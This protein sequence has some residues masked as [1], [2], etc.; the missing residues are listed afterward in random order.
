[1]SKSLI[2]API[3]GFPEFLPGEQIEFDKMLNVVRRHYQ[4]AGFT[5]IETPSIERMETLRAAKA[6]DEVKGQMYRVA[7]NLDESMTDYGLHFDLTVPFARYVAQHRTATG[8]NNQP[9]MP[10]P[11]RRSQIQKVW[12]G[13]KTQGGRYREFYQCDIDAIGDGELSHLVDAEIPYVMYGIFK[14]LDFGP[15]MIRINNRKILQG[16]MANLGLDLDQAKHAMGILDELEKVGI[17]AVTTKLNDAFS[18]SEADARKLINFMQSQEGKTVDESLKFLHQ[19]GIEGL[20]N[21]GLVELTEMIEGMRLWGVPES[22]FCI[23]LTIARGLDYYTGNVFETKLINHD[24][25][26]ICS[27]GRYDEL[28]GQFTPD[29]AHLPGVGASIGLTRLFP[30]LVKA[31]LVNV[32]RQTVADV[33]V[34]SK[35]HDQMPQYL[36]IAKD[37]RDAGIRTELFTE[38]TPE[39][40]FFQR[41]IKYARN[42]GYPLMIVASTDDIKAGCVKLENPQTGESTSV[43]FNE[44]VEA[45]KARL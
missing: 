13:E 37:L 41:Q 34:T 21:A 39:K 31:G 26:S 24:I 16:F 4:A 42:K 15:F 9:I 36:Q 32:D 35:D 29:Q 6:G 14:E 5:P 8:A 12:R 20:F 19:Q 30:R 23:D 27:G 45:V 38:K 25:G 2:T 7:R 44:L 33:L 17:S 18:L 10:F 1:M 3:A 22:V 28:A 11:F 40:K 43:V